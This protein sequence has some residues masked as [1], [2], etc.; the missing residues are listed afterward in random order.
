MLYYACKRTYEWPL[1]PTLSWAFTKQLR[2]KWV[3]E[4]KH[5]NTVIFFPFNLCNSKLRE[6]ANHVDVAKKKNKLLFLTF[7]AVFIRLL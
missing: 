5:P 1:N 4:A 7:I 2:E 6:Y 3:I